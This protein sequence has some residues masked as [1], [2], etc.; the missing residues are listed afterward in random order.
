MSKPASFAISMFEEGICLN[1]KEYVLDG[2]DGDVMLFKG[3]G[4]AIAYL[5]STW[6]D[7]PE[8]ADD[9]DEYG[10][11]IEPYGEEDDDE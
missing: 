3:V 1:P 11:F 2:P 8:D 7:M 6:E 5:R 4:D 9:L 10:I